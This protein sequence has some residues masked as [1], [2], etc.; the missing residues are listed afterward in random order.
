MEG[1]QNLRI[2]VQAKRRLT[3]AVPHAVQAAG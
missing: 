2:L 3:S 1:K